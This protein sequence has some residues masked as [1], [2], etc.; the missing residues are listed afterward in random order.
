MPYT[1]KP[2]KTGYRVYGQDGTPL[3]KKPLSLRRAKKQKIA[4][5]ISEAE[6]DQR[7]KGKGKQTIIDQL[8]EIGLDPKK[9]LQVAREQAEDTGYE[10]FD[11]LEFS[12]NGVHK[13]QIP[14]EEGK[15][16]RFGRVG[17]GDFLIWSYLEGKGEAPEGQAEKKRNVFRK[18]HLALSEKRNITD[19]YAPN[20]LAINILW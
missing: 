15:I 19:P 4:V 9:Y 13:L 10:N 3:S 17:Y 12:M 8:E 5:N 2:Y 14:N 20:N 1:I 16:I 6:Q 11:E 18:S 7:M